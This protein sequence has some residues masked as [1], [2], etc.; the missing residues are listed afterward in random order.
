M[1]RNIT[2]EFLVGNGCPLVSH[3]FPFVI[4]LDAPLSNVSDA[5]HRDAR[6]IETLPEIRSR[7]CVGRPPGESA[8]L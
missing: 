2:A 4:D 7:G 5:H 8:F 3:E 6:L 1:A